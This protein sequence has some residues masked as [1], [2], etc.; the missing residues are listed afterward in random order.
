M[1]RS[2][3]RPMSDERGRVREVPERANAAPPADG[4]LH[5]LI[6]ELAR[7]SRS[8]EARFDELES[9]ADRL[10]AQVEASRQRLR[11]LI[12]QLEL[13]EQRLQQDSPAAARAPRQAANG[14]DRSAP[15][16][17]VDGHAARDRLGRPERLGARERE[18]LKLLTEGMHSPCIAKKLGIKTATVE[19]HRRNIMRKL[20]LHSIAALTKYA[21]RA[22]LTSL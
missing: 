6:A 3:R 12:T 13:A 14:G 1:L 15:R 4:P 10:H 5:E 18:V 17:A 20:N 7:D 19:V 16:L 11:L 8:L 21:V 9:V 2:G 22:G